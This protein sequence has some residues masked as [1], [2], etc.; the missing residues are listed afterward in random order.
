MK[1]ILGLDLGTSS[2]GWA[3]VN[4]AETAAETSNIV[5]LGVRVN[6]LTVDEQTNF[7]KGKPITT[8]ADR[9]LKRSMRRSLQ[10][11]KLRRQHLVELLRR[12][13]WITTDTLLSEQGNRSTFQTY[14]LRA[15]AA[16]EEITLEELARVLLMINKKRGY[17]SSRKA[18]GGDEG[19]LVD[20]MDAA[21]EMYDEGLTPGTYGMIQL[22]RGGTSFLPEFYRSDLVAELDKIWAVQAPFY[23][24]VLTPEFRQQI[25]RLS[26]K[27]TQALFYNKYNITAT[28]E[29][30]KG[31]NRLLGLYLMRDFA[32]QGQ[33]PL[34]DVAQ[35]V[36]EVNGQINGSSGYLG[37]ISDRSKELYFNHQ[38]I[39]Q[40]LMKRLD[41]DPN[42]SLKNQP[43]YRQ[44][45]MDEFE[46]IW[47][48][49]AKFHPQLTPELKHEVRDIVIF[50]QRRLK[51][52]K[53]LVSNCEF[54]PT[55]KVCPKS[56]PIFQEFK[57]LQMLN[58]VTVSD[59][60]L[61]RRLDD[62]ERQ[63]LLDELTYRAELSERE[64]LELLYTRP[65]GLHLN[66][67]K[68]EGNRTMA[69]LLGA[70]QTILQ[71][72]GAVELDFVHQRAEATLNCVIEGFREQGMNTDWLAFDSEKTGPELDSQPLYRL[73]HLLYSYEGDNSATGTEK[74]A[75]H[76]ATLLNT[77][78][79]YPNN[80]AKIFAAV[81]FEDDY[82]SLSVKA[83][84]RI[85]PFL[86]AGHEYSE[87]CALAGYRHSAASLTRE[88]IAARP[89]KERLDLLPRNSLRNPVVEKILNQMANVVNGVIAQYGRPDEVRIELAR[90]LKKN[91]AE[92]E[93]LT[94]AISANTKEQ[95]RVK[96]ILQTEFGIANPSRNDIVRYR[97]YMELESNG[98]RTLYSNKY[99]SQEILF[100]K[101]VDIEH[102]IPQARLFDDSFSN[103]TLEFRAENIEKGN[104]TALD[105]VLMKYGEQGAADY[106]ARIDALA[107]AGAISTAKAK[108]LKMTT[109]D[110]PS[111]FIERDLRNTQYISRKAQEM[112]HDIARTVT[113]TT[114]TITD[115]LRDDWQ[116]V[117]VM[118]EL[119]WAKYNAQ[120]LTQIIERRDGQRIRHITDWTK[121]NDH[122]HH[123]MDALAIAFTKPAYIQYL[124]NLNA[125]SNK[126]G[127]IYGIE[128]KELERN[129]GH[130]RFKSP[131]MPVEAF[132][133][134]AKRQLE[135]VLVSIK[136][137]NKVVTRN[138]NTTKTKNG[139]RSKVQLTP[140]GQLHKETVCSQ[141]KVPCTKEVPVGAKMDAQ[142]IA[143]VKNPNY[144]QA[145]RL[146]LEAFGGD[147]K[148][149]FTGK[150]SL[151]KNP[152]WL[153]EQHS[154]AVPNK[155]MIE[156][157]ELQYTV[158]KPI[159][160]DLKLEKVVDEGVR[161]ILQARLDEFGGDAAKA[162]SN[163]DDNPIWLN[164]AK[165]IPIKSVRYK[166]LN[167][168]VALHSQRD[169]E[170]RLVVDEQ[171]NTRPADFVDTG[172]NHHVAI[173]LDADG[174]LQEHIVSFYEATACA[175]QGLPIVD[176]SYNQAQGWQFLFTMKQNEYFVFP[177][178]A[179]GFDPNQVDLMDER[180]YSRISPNLF[181]VQNMSKGDYYFRHHLETTVEDKSE[182]KGI[183]WKRIGTKAL[184]GIVKV[185][186]NHIGKIVQVGEY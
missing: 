113:A 91:A 59:G 159:S 4:E 79:S 34:E 43:F 77:P 52:Q 174:N 146:R 65:R 180:N 45:Y 101:E 94:K 81:T 155:V 57:T 6:P 163:L 11:Y 133:E 143:L 119:N 48:T 124:N 158:K 1:K 181:R 67:K 66:F 44:D 126:A 46:A 138:T 135:M 23:P 92:R 60:E 74:L 111:D 151:E 76:I 166:H 172:N 28:K 184:V 54:E 102:I 122:R 118:K 106:K 121:R 89:L 100:S 24:E 21:R 182:L 49:Q 3:L 56:S 171:G 123:A 33:L 19:Q 107:K 61:T 20:G 103:K 147:A 165:G 15:K 169:K 41:A 93:A 63:T 117:D 110:I 183:T 35:A 114:G 31:F 16:T 2:I 58:N 27:A 186:V 38:T 95:E 62:D 132:R 131:I 51:S 55:R 53:G 71:H 69:A 129:D 149:A 153:D 170:G 109:D 104:A 9:T 115:R 108:K 22:K 167:N 72:P 86:K 50:Y 176:R 80:Y 157:F 96:G 112:L 29:E 32:V 17:K 75:Q 14:R 83:M 136:A 154:R 8:N 164:R 7:E 40:Y 156:W 90:E 98:F 142:A 25:A 47:E 127:A 125:R 175:M 97:L 177:D 120:G 139:T 73:W 5:R 134:E 64:A 130:L 140:R 128:Q 68:L 70:C 30:G 144:R 145:L 150:N 87:A 116:L 88:E 82:G 162:F 10:R 178:P 105:Y 141:M 185:R 161:R 42:A 18:K 179:T 13:G 152:L 148:K 85:L 168:A 78:T 137:K 37:A 26:K 39:G 36:S 84:Q 99:I 173:F 12:E 160:K